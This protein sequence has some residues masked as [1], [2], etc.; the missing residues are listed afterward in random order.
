M[1]RLINLI[2]T[3]KGKIPLSK[4]AKLNSNREPSTITIDGLNYTLEVYGNR[5]KVAISHIMAN[6][7]EQLQKVK[8]N[9]NVEMEQI[10]EQK[11]FKASAERMV[12]AIIV[13]VFLILFTLSNLFPLG[14]RNPIEISIWMNENAKR[15]EIKKLLGV[16]FFKAPKKSRLYDFFKIVDK[17]Y[18]H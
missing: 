7:E 18:C 3:P 8:L 9:P 13:A 15:K 11:Q 16:E 5:E 14:A 10:G 4:I 6:L 1:S 2:V 17:E 12:G